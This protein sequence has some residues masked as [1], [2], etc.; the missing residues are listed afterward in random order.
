[1]FKYLVGILRFYIIEGVSNLKKLIK[2]KKTKTGKIKPLDPACIPKYVNELLKPPVYKPFQI[3]SKAKTKKKNKCCKEK[4]KKHLYF[5]DISEFKQQILPKGFPKTTVWGYGGLVKD[6]KTGKIKYSRSAPGATFEAVRNIPVMVKWI[7]KLKC[8]NRFAVDPTLHWAN[9]NDMPMEP[10]KPWPMFPQGFPEAQRPVTTV[11]HLHGGEVPSI[12]DGHPDAWFTYNGKRGPA[13]T[14]SMYSYPN[15]QEPTTLWYHDHSLGTT[16]LNVYAGLAGFYLLRDYYNGS[17]KKSEL[18][19]GKYEIPIVIQDRSFY[20]D[21][22]FSF[23]NEGINPE[24]HPYWVPEF[25][26]NTIMVNGSVWPNL[27]VERRQY[28]IRLLNGSNARFYN[29]EMS[30]RMKFIQIGTDGGFLPEPVVLSTLL[31]APG[32]RAD[33]LVDFSH[34]EPGT[35]IKLLNN[36]NTPFP[37]GEEPDPNTVGQIMQFSVPINCAKPIEPEKLPDKLNNIPTLIPDSP[38]RIL[39]L[40]EVMGLNG[41]EILL[42]NGQKW[43]APVSELPIVGSTQEWV[44]ANLTMDT[45]PIHL[46]L[47]QYQ[48]L[49]RQDFNADE[50]KM[51]WEEINGMPPFDH[52]TEVLPVECYLLG[53]PIEPDDNEKGWKDTVRMNPNQVTRI[54]VRFAPQNTP[55]SIVKPGKNRYPFDPTLGPGYVWHCHILDHEDNEMMRPFNVINKCEH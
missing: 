40:N 34:L 55:N 17:K 42:L 41:P 28:R 11:T 20:T 18:P 15:K 14:T 29:L 12:Y 5:V 38:Q 53:E 32:E 7:N 35:S 24:I 22:S 47:V 39:T 33:I 25:L 54:I 3:K 8:S 50:Y 19:E 48:L 21:G 9:P 30:N 10:P 23:Y 52:P 49:N 36:A 1:M 16:R 4:E 45:H 37:D 31:I 44:I 2:K 13:F 27:N 6:A 46:H 26:G 51:K 43:E